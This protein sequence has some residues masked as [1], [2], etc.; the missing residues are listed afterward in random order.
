MSVY[1]ELCGFALD[2]RSCGETR[3][4]LVSGPDPDGRYRV[5]LTC[6]CGRELRR[7][8]TRADAREDLLHPASSVV[9]S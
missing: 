2:H 6:S 9:E 1:D 7:S 8:V 5:R 4:H 3:A